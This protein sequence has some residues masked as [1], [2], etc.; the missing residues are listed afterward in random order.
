MYQNILD[1]SF[2]IDV[3]SECAYLTYNVVLVTLAYYPCTIHITPNQNSVNHLHITHMNISLCRL[4]AKIVIWVCV[5]TPLTGGHIWAFLHQVLWPL[6]N[7]YIIGKRT[8][9]ALRKVTET[10]E[11]SPINKQ[12][13]YN[14]VWIWILNVNNYRNMLYRPSP[15]WFSKSYWRPMSNDM[16]RYMCI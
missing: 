8:S 14:K 12:K 7:R 11:K 3:T 16:S 13:N 15:H 5:A 4:I 6:H 9:E 1:V 10:L 2:C